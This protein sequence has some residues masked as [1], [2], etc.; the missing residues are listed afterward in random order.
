MKSYIFV[1]LIVILLFP[2]SPIW[3]T[4]QIET[5]LFPSEDEIAE[6]FYLGEISLE[7]Y[8]ILTELISNGVENASFLLDEIPQS[9]LKIDTTDEYQAK[10]FIESHRDK[11]THF[12][13]SNRYASYIE[14]NSRYRNQTSCSYT[15]QDFLGHLT[16][17]REFSNRQR[18]TRRYIAYSPENKNYKLIV[19]NFVKQFGLG[20]VI[21]YSGKMLSYSDEV[22]TESFLFPDYGGFNGLYGQIINDKIGVQTVTSFN[23]NNEY[24]LMTFGLS[25][26][27]NS[28]LLPSVITAYNSFENKVVSKSFDDIKLSLYKKFNYTNGNIAIEFGQ[29]INE[30]KNSTF[31]LSDGVYK[32]NRIKIRYGAW[33]Y[34]SSFFNFSGGGKTSLISEYQYIKSIDYTMLN[35]RTNQTGAI[36][37][38]QIPLANS[39]QLDIAGLYAYKNVDTTETELYG[40]VTKELNNSLSFSVDLLQRIKTR[41]ETEDGTSETKTQSR[42]KCRYQTKKLYI[43]NYFSVLHYTDEPTYTGYFSEIKINSTHYGTIQFWLNAS[44]FNMTTKQLDYIYAFIKNEIEIQ[45]TI[46]IGFKLSHSYNRHAAKQNSNQFSCDVSWQI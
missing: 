12:L 18:F 15:S 13:I 3:G 6:A 35:K 32:T 11:T 25:L 23:R 26:Q 17:K 22:N 31:F 21:G 10:Y 45:K 9:L 27:P 2:I 34:N 33:N 41:I 4:Q 39:W 24:S 36:L 37:K 5:I 44:R 8:L 29:S 19:G 43:R 14:E 16:V 7:Q 46:S 40:Q 38:S 20:G 28:K 42:F 1:I 30:Q